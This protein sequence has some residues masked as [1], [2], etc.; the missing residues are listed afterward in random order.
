MTNPTQEEIDLALK[1]TDEFG[2]GMSNEVIL[3]AAYRD[4]C[5]DHCIANSRLADS[6]ARAKML[7]R[8]Y[9]ELWKAATDPEQEIDAVYVA[10][11]R[12]TA[13]REALR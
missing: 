10:R 5:V 1:S 2:K 12:H 4:K 6:E 9:D 13:E 7:E 11:D 3:A 8:Q